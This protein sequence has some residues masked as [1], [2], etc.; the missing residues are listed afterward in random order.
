MGRPIDDEMIAGIYTEGKL[1]KAIAAGAMMGASLFGG[2]DTVSDFVNLWKDYYHTVDD[3]KQNARAEAVLND[4]V[5]I[6]HQALNAINTA[7]N[8]FGGDMGVDAE[9]LRNLLIYTG[10]VESAYRAKRE[11]GGGGASGYW[12]V[13]PKTVRDH[14]NTG[15]NLLGPKFQQQFSNEIEY[16]NDNQFSDQSII[17]LLV[18][19]DEFAAAMAAMT[20]I[21]QAHKVL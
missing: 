11:F 17:K 8:I 7:V 19:N 1:S 9:K 18:D 12:Q 14:F 6:P 3:P 2:T 16:L 21:R 20:W 13:L 5:D 4:G 15:K 10:E